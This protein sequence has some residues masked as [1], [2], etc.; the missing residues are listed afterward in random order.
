M[1]VISSIHTGA[2]VPISIKD[3]IFEILMAVEE[4]ITVYK[5][6][7]GAAEIPQRTENSQADFKP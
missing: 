5:N 1:E 4:N 3:D 2:K 6:P 7:K